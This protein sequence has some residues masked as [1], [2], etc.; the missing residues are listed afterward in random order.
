MNIKSKTEL[1]DKILA[2]IYQNIAVEDNRD[3][4]IYIKGYNDDAVSR[5]YMAIANSYADVNGK[6][7]TMILPLISYI[8]FIIKNWKVRKRYK[9]HKG[10]STDK[11]TSIQDIADYVVKFF[12]Q[13]NTIYE[14]IYKEYYE[15]K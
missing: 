6:Q 1:Y 4:G 11:Y 2:K 5:D 12:M 8:I 13:P 9:R 14:D 15:N 7:I 3:N 10:K